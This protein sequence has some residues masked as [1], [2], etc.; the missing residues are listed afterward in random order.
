MAHILDNWQAYLLSPGIVAGALVVGLLAHRIAFSILAKP[1]LKLSVVDASRVRHSRRP[2][3]FILPL[4]A[5]I[6][7]ERVL[8]VS[9]T[10]KDAL[11]SGELDCGNSNRAQPAHSN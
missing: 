4:L 10:I 2:S 8:P 6:I 11:H 7:A 5:V 9:P 1:S 3:T